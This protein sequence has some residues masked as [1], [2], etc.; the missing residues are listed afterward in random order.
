MNRSPLCLRNKVLMLAKRDFRLAYMRVSKPLL[1]YSICC[2]Y[3][4]K[5]LIES[6]RT[7]QNSSNPLSKTRLEL[8]LLEVRLELLFLLITWHVPAQTPVW[9]LWR[10][11]IFNA[12]D[13]VKNNEWNIFFFLYFYILPTLTLTWQSTDTL[14][15]VSWPICKVIYS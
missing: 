10:N 11:V 8:Q 15:R 13:F 7:S 2:I 6:I 3:W 14:M 9:K 1:I 12:L 5:F 4:I